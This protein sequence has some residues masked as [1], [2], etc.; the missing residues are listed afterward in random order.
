MSVEGQLVAQQTS[1]PGPGRELLRLPAEALEL[2]LVA[3]LA[4]HG[5]PLEDLVPG[6]LVVGVVDLDD[7]L[8]VPGRDVVLAPLPALPLHGVPE[9]LGAGVDPGLAGVRVGDGGWLALC[10]ERE[11]LV[12]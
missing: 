6:R 4:V 2:R 9:H 11:G 1:D 5:L 10:G 8:H 3:L 12:W 7:V